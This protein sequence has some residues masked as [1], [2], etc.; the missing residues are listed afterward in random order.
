MVFHGGNHSR[1]RRGWTSRP[2]W[3]RDW[4]GGGSAAFPSRGGPGGWGPV[5]HQRNDQTVQEKE[6]FGLFGS[7][8][9]KADV[10]PIHD[11]P[12][13]PNFSHPPPTIPS[14]GLLQ[15]TPVP[16]TSEIGPPFPDFSRPPP[17][18][19]LHKAKEEGASTSTGSHT[20]RI[21]TL[22]VEDEQEEHVKAKKPKLPTSKYLLSFKSFLETQDDDITEEESLS[23]YRE[24]KA[25][26]KR[27]QNLQFFEDHKEEEWLMELYH[28]V[29]KERRKLEEQARVARRS[30]VFWS[31]FEHGMGGLKMEVGE[32]EKLI[33][34]MDGF[35]LGLGKLERKEGACSTVK[36][37]PMPTLEEGASPSEDNVDEE[38]PAPLGVSLFLRHVPLSVP[39]S[40]VEELGRRC[41]GFQ[42]VALGQVTF[43]GDG[44]P[45]RKA[46]ITYDPTT[47]IKQV[48][49]LVHGVD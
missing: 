43:K 7:R 38:E 33:K 6:Y 41:E 20:K 9:E 36:P 44:Q 30:D 42:R 49:F 25:E 45:M 3:G 12:L 13:L 8:Q 16:T 4:R 11:A 19:E 26:H 10:A 18:T 40:M 21:R 31:I 27:Q 15:M 48:T 22:D 46:W 35:V 34:A 47:D 14:E 17:V 2:G 5:H 39:A 1:D 23:L 32:E 24:Y 29:C 37:E 28:P